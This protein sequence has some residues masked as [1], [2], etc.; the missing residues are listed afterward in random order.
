MKIVLLVGLVVGVEGVL[1]KRPPVSERD[2][3]VRAA[4]ADLVNQLVAVLLSHSL[5]FSSLLL[6]SFSLLSVNVIEHFN[7]RL[8][9]VVIATAI[10]IRVLEHIKVLLL[11]W[12]QH[13]LVH[14]VHESAR[15]VTLPSHLPDSR[16]V[17]GH[18]A[19][20]QGFLG[21]KAI[22]HE[23]CIEHSL[24]GHQGLEV[25][26]QGRAV[27]WVQRLVVE[28][29]RVVEVSPVDEVLDVAV[30]LSLRSVLPLLIVFCKGISD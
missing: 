9:D 14:R 21:V 28:G 18:K 15:V 16:S 19:E 13:P 22:L 10:I 11:H 5:L 3:A 26:L 24:L 27:A 6:I 17:S 8:V 29:E 23:H 30:L 4:W 2:V 20:T 7:I 25:G 12:W 1:R